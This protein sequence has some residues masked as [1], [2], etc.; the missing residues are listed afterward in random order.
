MAL[1]DLLNYR[2][3]V[4]YF[5]PD[6]PLDSDKVK[7]C[8]ELATLAPTSSNMQLYEFYHITDKDLLSQLATA[9]LGQQAA[10]TAQQMVVFVTRQDLYQE[11]AADVLAFEIDNIKRHSPPDR[12]ENRIKGKKAYYAKLMPFVYRRAFGLLGL[13][14][15]ALAYAI[16]L[17]R[18]ISV[19]VSESDMRVTTHKSCA[20]VA[21]TFMLAMAEQGYDTCPLEGLDS[22][23]VKKILD[24]PK[25]AEVNMIVSC[26]V[27]KAGR[28]IW[29]D[30]YRV[31]FETVYQQ[32]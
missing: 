22:L 1:S 8:L 32:R 3:A 17:K 28:G 18:P 26:G 10:T 6:V 27:R 31:P 9:C 29:G 16:H 30:R 14:R 7:A 23:R 4:R 13:F 11:R 2:R 20:L 21:Q 24:L 19:N 15:K 25:G 12:W 5:D